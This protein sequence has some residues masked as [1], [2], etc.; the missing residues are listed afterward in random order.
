MFNTDFNLGT[1]A[2][3]NIWQSVIIFAVVFIILKVIRETS[4]E[5]KSWSWSATLFALAILPM[6]AFLPD[7]GFKWQNEQAVSQMEFVGT[8]QVEKPLK[9]ISKTKLDI[10]EEA[11]EPLLTMDKILPYLIILWFAGTLFSL[12]KL[13]VAGYNAAKLRKSA[14]PYVAENDDWQSDVEIAIS[15]EVN[16]PIVIGILK[17]LILLPRD[18]VHEIDF[19]SLRPLLFHELAHIKRFDNIFNLI[20]RIVL[21]VYWW[22]PVMHFIAGRISE[23]RE[24]ACDD[25]AARSCGDQMFYA[26]SLLNGAKKLVGEKKPVLGLAVLRRESPLSKRVKRLMG[27]TALGGVNMMRFAKNLSALFMAILMLGIMTPRF[28]VG[29]VGVDDESIAIETEAGVDNIEG[30]THQAVIEN[31]PSEEELERIIEQAMADMP[32]EEELEIILQEAMAD[33]PTE[34]ELEIILQ[35]A[36]AEMPSEEEM[37]RIIAE[38]H[39]DMPTEEEFEIIFQE[40]IAEMPTEEEL[41][42]IFA[43]AKAGMPSLEVVKLALEAA[44]ANMPSL[45][46]M[47]LSLEA[48][49]ASMPSKEEMKRM[50]EEVKANMPSAEELEQMKQEMEQSMEE[51][52]AQR[53]EMRENLHEFHAQREEMLELKDVKE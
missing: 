3:H 23:E 39:A 2:G 44:K 34:E 9:A 11:Q 43:E 12:F 20:E 26:K 45:E 46:V 31:M 48:A 10:T 22:N 40:A 24:L 52:R 7:E 29:Q 15:D 13:A 53:E 36:M 35:K 37:A 27:S 4:A 16:G 25:R 49:K 14:Y 32:T 5:E 1:L 17:P 21:S 50:L 38:A 18:F 6:A 42:R 8:M 41:E 30:E 47:K 33:M 19:K 28:A 51:F